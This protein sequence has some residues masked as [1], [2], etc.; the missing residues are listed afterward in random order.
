MVVV[1]SVPPSSTAEDK[2]TWI[3][4]LFS[5]DKYNVGQNEEGK[6]CV[7][8]HDQESG[9]RVIFV[10]SENF[11]GMF[12]TILVKGESDRAVIVHAQL[13]SETDI[14]VM[15]VGSIREKAWRY[16]DYRRVARHL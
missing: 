11:S 14:K 16:Q 2:Q 9:D 4:S 12:Y 7:Y 15:R 10:F 13:V 3:S 5:N 8:D 1:E 6:V